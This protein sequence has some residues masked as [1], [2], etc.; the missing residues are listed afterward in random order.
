MSLYKQTTQTPNILFDE[1]L[2]TLTRSELTVLMTIIRKTIGMVNPKDTYK[3]VDK[4][5]ISQ[6]LFAIC[7][8]LSPR[9]VSGAIDSL[10]KKHLFSVTNSKGQ[11]L[12]TKASRRGVFKLYYS[13][14]LLLEHNLEKRKSSEPTDHKPVTNSNIIKLTDTKLLR[15]ERSQG[16]KKIRKLTDRE[17]I[18]QIFEQQSRH[19]KQ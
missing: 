19:K 2:K 10:V 18:Q 14:S 11:Y 1:Y 12:K 6:R 13:S 3:R 16:F 17:R 7:T 4:A 9:A 5:W 8:G 15:E